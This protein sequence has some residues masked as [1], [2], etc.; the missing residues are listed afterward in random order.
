MGSFVN[1]QNISKPTIF[2]KKRKKKNHEHGFFKLYQVIFIFKSQE[3]TTMS[4]WVK[5]GEKFDF[6]AKNHGLCVIV[7]I[8]VKIMK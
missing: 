3:Q 8:S 5:A 6:R 2:S 7:S 4:T 1:F